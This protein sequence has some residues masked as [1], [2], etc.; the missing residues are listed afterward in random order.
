[1]RTASLSILL[2]LALVPRPAAGE[3][4]DATALR[5][6]A[7]IASSNDGGPS[8]A[9]LRFANSDAESVSR[10]LG[11]LGGVRD[12][13]LLLLRDTSRSSLTQ[14]F[15][16]LRTLVGRERRPGVRREVL[17]YFSGHSDEEGLLLA[18]ERVTYR[19]LRQWIDAVG[20]EVRI[21]IL[22][23]CA[24]GALI[25]LKGGVHRA[26]FLS[27]VSTQA[28]GHAFLTASSANEAAQESDRVGAAFFTH[29]L[30]SGMR[31]AA[32]ANR[33]RR[34][35]LNEAYQFAYHET[36]QRTEASRAGAQHPA[37]DIQLAG[38]G[39]VVMTDLRASSA[40][41]VLARELA[42]RIYVRDSA[43]RL[44]VELRKEPTYPVELG[45][46]P[47]PYHVV[48]DRDGSISK[49]EVSV[50]ASGRVEIAAADLTPVAPLVTMRR[51]DEPQAVSPS[52]PP[53]VGP[54]AVTATAAPTRHYRRVG[55]DLVLAPGYRMSGDTGQPVEHGFV[56]GL[57]G[58]S[59][60][61]RGAQ[62]SLAG[63]IAQDG[64][65]GAQVGGAVA[66]SYGPVLG[67]QAAGYNLAMGGLRGA[68]VGWIASVANRGV[69]GVQVSM[70]NIANGAMRG[71]QIGVANLERGS[72]HGVQIG[73]A[74]VLR[75]QDTTGGAQIGV[76]NVTT[77]EA[78][79]NAASIG[80][81]NVGRKQRGVQIGLVNVAD[82]IDGAQI[83]LISYARKNSGVSIGL[84]P[85]VRD[86]ENHLTLGWTS[87]TAANLGF[88]LGTRRAYMAA[89]IGITRDTN[90]DGD[91]YYATSFGF[92][93]H[94]IPRDRRFFLDIGASATDFA[95]WPF[96]HNAK[97]LVSSLRL[98][99][100]YAIARRLAVVAGP[101]LNVQV[102][103]DG[104]D[105]RP[106]GVS[107]AEKVWTSDG[108][109]TTRL[110]PGI[111]AGLEF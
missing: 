107:F 17:V 49:S 90:P 60:R 72:L 68:Q 97:R 87:T 4:T 61:V 20:G 29:F 65:I 93:I 80:V 30:L 12:G 77:G 109:T 54:P 69:E 58:H 6:F 31:G 35:T 108:G 44:V 43:D 92:G 64:V 28:R 94:A 47:G 26:P 102:A 40:R 62:V 104:E 23:S 71:A 11:S 51:G 74:N 42:G 89:A 19:E 27:D 79:R 7:L 56:L 38:T 53:S 21:G 37:Y 32:D 57:L 88:K 15:A 55:F 78:V 111:E 105:R 25:R 73:V 86:G 96:G 59:D 110:Y 98:Q 81:V 16:E 82:E 84:F 101:C 10:L 14:G 36:L 67:A 85:M 50:P 41:L 99:A 70:A 95:P 24:S 3:N 5:R 9:R 83:G 13:D 76:A 1:M 33:D 2:L 8:R 34:V 66:L 103:W 63:N 46:E 22:D 18:N 75:A 100:G 106:R 48:L 52:A 39:D 91:R 45:L